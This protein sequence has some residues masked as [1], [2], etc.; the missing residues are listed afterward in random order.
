MQGI[1]F[2]ILLTSAIVQFLNFLD[3]QELYACIFWTTNATDFTYPILETSSKGPEE[4]KIWNP[5][6]DRIIF[7]GCWIFWL[8]LLSNFYN[9]SM[10][11]HL[12]WYVLPYN[13]RLWRNIFTDIKHV[14][15]AWF[16]KSM[17]FCE[18]ILF[19]YPKTWAHSDRNNPIF[20][21]YVQNIGHVGQNTFIGFVD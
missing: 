3:R 12:H 9:F 20:W 19:F 10:T 14:H 2:V 7:T 21:R 16:L 17:F 11:L 6:T 18:S 5:S 8:F 15:A 1:L 4:S 13:R